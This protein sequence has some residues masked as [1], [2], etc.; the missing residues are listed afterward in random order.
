MLGTFQTMR[1]L[2]LLALLAWPFV[3]RAEGIMVKSA[4]LQAVDDAYALNASFD[5]SLGQ[6][7]E[8]ALKKGMPLYFLV[9][10]ELTRPRFSWIP[11]HPWLDETAVSMQRQYKLSYNAL[12]RQYMLSIETPSATAQEGVMRGIGQ[13]FASLEQVVQAMSRIRSWQV[14]ERGVMKKRIP[15]EASLRM[16]L[17]VS[18]LPKPL[19]VNALTSKSWSLE[20]DRFRWSLTP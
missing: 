11:A 15:H 8:E 18:L 5:I 9:E 3:L 19:Q 4:E 2:V 14:V 1:L 13:S 7:L 10:F 6:T 17:D 12:L 16:K 20:S